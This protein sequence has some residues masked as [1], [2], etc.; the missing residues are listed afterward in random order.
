MKNKKEIDIID[1]KYEGSLI[2]DNLFILCI[3]NVDSD[4]EDVYEVEII[5]DLG[6]VYCRSDLL[7]VIGGKVLIFL[8]FIEELLF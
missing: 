8:F 1:L 2:G 7:K 3:N 6:K 5:N 4:D